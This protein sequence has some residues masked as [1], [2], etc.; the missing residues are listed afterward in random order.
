MRT[1][2]GSL[3]HKS[4]ELWANIRKSIGFL[5]RALGPH[6]TCGQVHIRKKAQRAMIWLLSNPQFTL[7]IRLK[8]VIKTRDLL[9]EYKRKKKKKKS[10]PEKGCGESNEPEYA[11]EQTDTE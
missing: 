4:N 9:L 11:S 2:R 3:S 7:G 5:H 8:Y 6:L 10:L 1:R